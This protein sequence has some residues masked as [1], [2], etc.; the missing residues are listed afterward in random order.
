MIDLTY[1]TL[2]FA[3]PYIGRPKLL[4]TSA[5]TENLIVKKTKSTRE[6][7]SLYWQTSLSI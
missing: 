5:E 4:I 6:N 3:S 1:K 2:S 7:H